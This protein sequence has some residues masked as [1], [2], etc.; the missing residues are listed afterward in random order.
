[1]G[2]DVRLSADH[3][4]L[5]A[6][7]QF[8]S[9]QAEKTGYDFGIHDQKKGGSHDTCGASFSIDRRIVLSLVRDDFRVL[10]CRQVAI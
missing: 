1:M 6:A 5:A 4:R 3:I 2:R 9:D 10:V 8:C 7:A